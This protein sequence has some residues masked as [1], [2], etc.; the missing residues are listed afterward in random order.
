MYL[1]L[2]L[3]LNME[4]INPPISIC[5]DEYE[6]LLFDSFGIIKLDEE[7]YRVPCPY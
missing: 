4:P 3:I 5:I 2:M 1:L 7:G 6:Y